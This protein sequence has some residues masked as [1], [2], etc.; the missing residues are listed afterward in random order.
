MWCWYE[1]QR[2]GTGQVQKRMSDPP[3]W[4]DL[5]VVLSYF[6]CVLGTK[7]GSFKG[8]GIV[9]NLSDIS[10]VLEPSLRRIYSLLSEGKAWRIRDEKEDGSL[11]EI[12]S[13]STNLGLSL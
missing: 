11:K 4:L 6:T 8:E 13:Y 7:L 2:K 1:H 5:R 9:L 3:I 12:S 10:K